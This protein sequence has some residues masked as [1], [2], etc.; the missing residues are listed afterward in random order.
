VVSNYL[1]AGQQPHPC[2]NDNFTAAPSGTFRTADGPL[3][4]AANKQ[5]QFDALVGVLGRPELAADP[6][7]AERECRKRNR[8]ALTAELEASLAAK[9]AVEWEAILNRVGIPAG[10]VLTVP[11]ALD[12]PQ[13]KHRELLQTFDDAPGVGRAVTVTRAGFK[14]SSGNPSVSA[15]PPRLGEHTEELLQ[16]LGYSGAEIA[17]LRSAGAI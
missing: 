10:R 6:R 13:I 11:E 4:I 17:E 2:G 12:N 1:I 15:P 9:S 5:E 8:A 14:M 3:N 16:G 7:F